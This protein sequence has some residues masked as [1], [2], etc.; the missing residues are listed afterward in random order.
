[1]YHSNRPEA[2]ENL[3]YL[4]VTEQ[5]FFNYSKELLFNFPVLTPF[6]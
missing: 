1:M 3:N 4:K 5:N 2:V 6:I